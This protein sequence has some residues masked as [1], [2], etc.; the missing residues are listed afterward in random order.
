MPDSSKLLPHD[1]GGIYILILAAGASKRMRGRDK[2]TEQ[3]EGIPLLRRQVLRGL[4]TGCQVFVTLP[5]PP[6][7]RYATVHDLDISMVPVADFSEG[8][9]ASLRAG[10]KAIPE[11]AN[12]VIVMLGD[13][14]NITENDLRKII[15]AIDLKSDIFIW[16]ATSETGISGHP[17]AFHKQLLSDLAALEGD[18]GGR[19]IVQQHLNRVKLIPLPSDHALIDLDT[20]EAWAKWHKKP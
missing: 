16:R 7:T 19:S 10:I 15:Q 8:I 9:N 1:T 17:I 2:L 18:V 3:I 6:H 20:P 13:M 14:P 4:D 11:T 12:A 5:P